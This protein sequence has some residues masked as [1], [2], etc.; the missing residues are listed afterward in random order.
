MF[1]ASRKHLAGEVRCLMLT[2]GVLWHSD[3]TEEPVTGEGELGRIDLKDIKECRFSHAG[4]ELVLA[5][6][7]K[8]HLLAAAPNSSVPLGQWHDAITAELS[9]LKPL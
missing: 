9:A 6:S 1:T 8:C 3:N 5:S 7:G 2:P 4:D